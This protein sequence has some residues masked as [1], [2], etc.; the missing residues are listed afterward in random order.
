MNENSVILPNAVIN[1]L[2]SILSPGDE[3]TVI[4]QID[5]Q[6]PRSHKPRRSRLPW[7]RVNSLPLYRGCIADLLLEFS[8]TVMDGRF[9]ILAFREISRREQERGGFDSHFSTPEYIDA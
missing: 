5:D 8:Y 9:H 6:L 2:E 1:S 7:F 4:E 3:L